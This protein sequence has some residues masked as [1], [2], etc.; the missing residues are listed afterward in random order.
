MC[1]V[2][3]IHIN[4]YSCTYVCPDLEM[5]AYIYIYMS[6]WHSENFTLFAFLRKWCRCLRT[7]AVIL[8]DNAVY[9]L[10]YLHTSFNRAKSNAN[11]LVYTPFV[12]I[13][14]I[15]IMFLPYFVLCCYSWPWSPH[16]YTCILL[17]YAY[18]FAPYV[19]VVYI[20]I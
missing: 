14:V 16:K 4:M 15:F 2:T 20:Y 13:V 7:I 5:H 19:L 10:A 12:L 17:V 18:S 8:Y 11:A 1:G 6:S 3:L 9:E